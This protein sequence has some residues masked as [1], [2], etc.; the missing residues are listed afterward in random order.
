MTHP[1][2]PLP[3]TLLA[4][5]M[6]LAGCVSLPPEVGKPQVGKPA[7]E[8]QALWRQHR[9]KMSG[10]SAW[11][12]KA[13]MAVTTGT[14]DDPKN[15]NATLTWAYR[16]DRQKIELY[17]PFGS[18]RVQITAEPGEVVLKDTK[19]KTITGANTAEVLYKR[20]GWQVPFEQLRYWVRGI[21][22]EGAA[23]AVGKITVD[24]AGRLKTLE[25]GNWRVAYQDYSSVNGLSLPEK[26]TVTA[27]PGSMEIYD[28]DGEYLGDLLRIK[29]ILQRWRDIQIDP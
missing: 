4:T 3:V 18:G 28:R 16:R 12:I 2:G 15:D 9:A 29:L 26:L 21:P 27:A 6:L 25:Q 23:D 17:G 5:F 13:K 1:A 14:R 20:L 19:G 10:V 24:S 8:A 11:H 22:G 7:G